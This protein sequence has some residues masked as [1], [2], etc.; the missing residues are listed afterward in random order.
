MVNRLTQNHRFFHVLEFCNYL[1]LLFVFVYP[2]KLLSGWNN[3]VPNNDQ[4]IKKIENAL[5]TLVDL[6]KLNEEQSSKV[7]KKDVKVL[8]K[9]IKV[10]LEK[11]DNDT[12]L[13]IIDFDKIILPADKIRGQFDKFLDKKE[14]QKEILKTLLEDYSDSP[15]ERQELVNSL[16][17]EFS[18]KE[19]LHNLSD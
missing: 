3:Q 7:L 4:L 6:D 16:I 14:Q 1:F 11:H 19:L 18:Y 2:F 9:L 13:Q 5:D 17:M 15:I 12:K 8:P 10:L